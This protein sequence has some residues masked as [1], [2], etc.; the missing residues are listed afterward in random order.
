MGLTPHEYRT[1]RRL[2][3]ARQLIARGAPLAEVA[4]DS[5]FADQ[6]HMNRLFLRAFGY[7]PGD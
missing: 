4:A 3:H 5:G 2:R 6:S 7:T 1:Q